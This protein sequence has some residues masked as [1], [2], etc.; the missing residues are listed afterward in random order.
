M[1]TKKAL[2]VEYLLEKEA[3]SPFVKNLGIGASAGLGVG[4]L[5][6]ALGSQGAEQG[7]SG[8]DRKRRAE[9]RAQME[10]NIKDKKPWVFYD[11]EH[12]GSWAGRPKKKKALLV[13]YLLEK[14]AISGEAKAR[15]GLLAGGAAGLAGVTGLSY[16]LARRNTNKAWDKRRDRAERWGDDA[17]AGKAPSEP[18]KRRTKNSALRDYL[19]EK[20]AAGEGGIGTGGLLLGA[21]GAAGLGLLLQHYFG[22]DPDYAYKGW[23]RKEKKALLAEY[24]LEKEAEEAEEGMGTAAKVG[25]G[26]VGGAALLGSG[27][28]GR[29]II[30]RKIKEK[31]LLKEITEQGE[32][33]RR[34][35]PKRESWVWTPEGGQRRWTKKGKASSTGISRLGPIS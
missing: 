1:T 34:A 19:L 28:L 32:V 35:E 2:L 33:K 7:I 16:G 6:L 8:V 27:L 24:L 22:K 3:A 10:Q 31:K 18:V 29:R 4:A 14:E 30:L 17:W 15:L 23:P 11:R 21:A 20:R 9:V 5:G 25:L 26:A 12:G 13:E